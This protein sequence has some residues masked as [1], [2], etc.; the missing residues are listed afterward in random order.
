VDVLVA[1]YDSAATL[2]ETLESARRHVPTHCL[3]VVDRASIDRTQEIARRYGARI[4]TEEVGLGAARNLSLRAADTDP[5]LFLDSDV[6]I[7]RPDFYAR[8]LQEYSRGGTA[9]VV[10]LAVGKPYRFGLPLGLTLVG[11][12]WAI[13][14]G[15]PDEA[16]GRET[17][18]LQRAARKESLRVRY[19]GEAMIHRGTYRRAAHWPEFQGAAIRRSS[20]LNP[21]ELVYAGL[22]VLLIHMNSKRPRNLLYS[23]IFYAKILRGFLAPDRWERLDR[24]GALLTSVGP[25]PR[26]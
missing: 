16:Q 2:E 18:Y 6:R 22:V 21:R 4:L 11:R 13:R 14:A 15:I 19:V 3:I 10:G 25:R 20:G 8:A 17:Y 7:V 9:A 1:T 24:H 26:T 23:P 5:V 12:S